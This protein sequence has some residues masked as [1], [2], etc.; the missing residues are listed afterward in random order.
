MTHKERSILSE[1]DIN[2][3]EVH[4]VLP[5]DLMHMN[6]MFDGAKGAAKTAGGVALAGATAAGM[7][8]ANGVKRALVKTRAKNAYKNIEE[9]GAYIIYGDYANKFRISV[10][11]LNNNNTKKKVT[12][13]SYNDILE[14]FKKEIQEDID[15]YNAHNNADDSLSDAATLSYIASKYKKLFVAINKDFTAI[16]EVS[17]QTDFYD[18][19]KEVVSDN[20]KAMEEYINKLITRFEEKCTPYSILKKKDNNGNVK[21]P[22]YVKKWSGALKSAWNKIKKNEISPKFDKL[23]R[24]VVKSS[25]FVTLYKLVEKLYKNVPTDRSILDSVLAEWENQ[26]STV[27]GNRLF[28][29]NLLTGQVNNTIS[30]DSNNATNKAIFVNINRISVQNILNQLNR[31]NKTSFNLLTRKLNFVYA[32]NKD[33]LSGAD[34]FVDSN[35]LRNYNVKNNVLVADANGN[36]PWINEH[37]FIKGYIKISNGNSSWNT[38]EGSILIPINFNGKPASVT[39]QQPQ[40]PS[41]P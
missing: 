17:G 28:E 29:W 4:A 11:I 38:M 34:N 2:E 19:T 41:N 31:T 30:I 24:D 6:G 22:E 3:K 21:I 37:I 10:N 12:I 16:K 20:V 7:G 14:L 39:Q 9:L 23:I 5:H 8:I 18:S 35:N 33:D 27:T 13:R 40:T 26:I 32:D 36:Y 25:E 1:S 15:D